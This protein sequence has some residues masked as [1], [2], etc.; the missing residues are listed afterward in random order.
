MA[1]ST[2]VSE[3]VETTGIPF[4]A[5]EMKFATEMVESIK[6]HSD[7]VTREITSVDIRGKYGAGAV[8]ALARNKGR[9]VMVLPGV[10]GTAKIPKHMEYAVTRIVV[11]SNDKKLKKGAKVGKQPPPPQQKH[12]Q[13]QQQ[14][15]QPAAE[16]EG[17]TD[18]AT[19]ITHPDVIAKPARKKRS[20]RTTEVK[21]AVPAASGGAVA[22]GDLDDDLQ[23]VLALINLGKPKRKR[24]VRNAAPVHSE[25]VDVDHDDDVDDVTLQ[26]PPSMVGSGVVG[27]RTSPHRTVFASTAPSSEEEDDAPIGRLSQPEPKKKEKKAKRGGRR[28]EEN[29]K[30]Q[31]SPPLQPQPSPSHQP[32]MMLPKE[33]PQRTTFSSSSSSSSSYT[34]SAW[35][36]DETK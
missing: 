28:V 32:Q 21:P 34:Y 29:N 30:P 36:Q 27:R 6:K 26:Y 20:T 10:D 15:Q 33:S 25:T 23:G 16:E 5:F 9:F 12:H 4:A 13:Q 2:A 17:S 31:P 1:T 7:T 24:T 19:L 22:E 8:V 35:T 3:Q 11:G 18:D 14:Q